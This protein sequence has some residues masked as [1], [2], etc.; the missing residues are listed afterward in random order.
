MAGCH[1]SK[2]VPRNEVQLQTVGLDPREAEA[3]E[4]CDS[5]AVVYRQQAKGYQV[6]AVVKKEEHE[7]GH[8]A[9]LTFAKDGKSFT[10]HTTSFGDTL[11]NK[12]GWGMDGTNDELMEKYRGKTIE[13]DYHEDREDGET[14]PHSTPFF[15]R[16]LDFDGV[17][18]L[19]IVHYAV[20]VR[21]HS[22]YDVYRIVE[23]APVLIGYPPFKTCDN[24]G[25][26]DYPEF[27]Y[28]AKKIS[29][30]YPEGPGGLGYL[31]CT[32]YGIS[33]TKK[34]TVVVNGRKHC[35]NHME[36]IEEIQYSR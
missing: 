34:D 12:G 25:M 30:P 13:A 11:F 14:M 19:V 15:F 6:K 32:I 3:L 10:L 31:G 17:E 24:Y 23:G 2:S 1:Q 21:Y 8:V 7:I 18:E 33:R 36:P 35:F 9:D 20:A 4:T 22:G 28:H 16:D 5:F 26:T 29:C 27:D